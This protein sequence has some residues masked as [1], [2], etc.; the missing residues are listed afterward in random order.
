ML[1]W[2]GSALVNAGNTV[3]RVMDL[4]GAGEVGD[5]G[6]IIAGGIGTARTVLDSVWLVTA[7]DVGI[8]EPAERSG[9]VWPNPTTGYFTL[10]LGRNVARGTFSLRDALGRQ[11]SVGAFQG[12][13]LQLDLRDRPA[14]IYMLDV[15]LG[16]A[17]VPY[18]LKVMR[19]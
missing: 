5:D 18:R 7:G 13:E 12:V 9:H 14:G 1:H 11:V 3:P 19:E 4:R 8:E 16:T 2:N 17:R 6:F 10:R 15:F